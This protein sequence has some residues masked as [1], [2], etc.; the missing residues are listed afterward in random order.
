ML[1]EH[2]SEFK[3][4]IGMNGKLSFLDEDCAFK[5]GSALNC[6]VA[7]TAVETREVE[8]ERVASIVR[9]AS[10]NVHAL[11]SELGVNAV[12]VFPFAHFPVELAEAPQSVEALKKLEAEI[13]LLSRG[14]YLVFRAPFGSHKIREGTVLGHPKAVLLRKFRV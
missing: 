6:L 12:V 11:A 3:W 14:T 1:L 4:R 2:M 5:S 13:A 10:R 8:K 9:K 7:Y